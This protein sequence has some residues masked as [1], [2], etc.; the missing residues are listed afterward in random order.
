MKKQK[1]LLSALD[2]YSMLEGQ[3]GILVGFSGGADSTALLHLLYEKCKLLG[4][5]LHA[6]HV[7]HGIRGEEADRDAEFCEG[8]CR[9]LGVDFTLVCADIPKMARDSGRGVEETARAFRYDEFAKIVR[10]DERLSCIATAHNADDNA[11]TVIFNLSRGSGIDGLCGIPPTREFDGILV[12]RPLIYSQ[13]C[14]IIGYLKENGIEYIF[15]ST[16]DDTRYTRN[17][18]RHE[19]IPRLA[20]VNPALLDSVRKMTENLRADA[21]CLERLTLAFVAENTVNGKISAKALLTADRAIGARAVR[22]MFA[23]H[24]GGMLERVHIDAVLALADNDKNGA[25]VSLVGGMR[26]VC[27]DGYI[28]F[29]GQTVEQTEFSYELH[30]GV[31]KFD[32]FAVILADVGKWDADLQKDNES[33]QN[34]YKLSTRTKINSDTINH[35]LYVRSRRDGDAYVFGE[36]TRKLKKL[37]ND[38]GWSLE[39]RRSTPVFCDD[40]GIV[41]VPEFPAADRALPNGDGVDIIYYYNGESKL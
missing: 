19:I 4:I 13:K 28:R 16:N 5:Y 40:T 23:E 33:L 10:S 1:S 34:I 25:S 15:D 37:Y 9:R 29:A 17:Y 39:K 30:P 12:I 6:L 36:M 38:R 24:C 26:A 22:H 32:K 20:S 31:N 21:D 11:E 18:I 3:S 14:D 35:M 7:H 41:W 8:T 2:T 27:E